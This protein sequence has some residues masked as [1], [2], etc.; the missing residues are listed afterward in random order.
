M[1]LTQYNYMCDEEFIVVA[2]A[3]RDSL[4]AGSRERELLEEVVNRLD[5]FVEAMLDDGDDA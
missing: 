4:P 5:H 1:I 2:K 3:Y